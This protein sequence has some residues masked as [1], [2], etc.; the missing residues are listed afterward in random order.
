MTE[1]I[2]PFVEGS[3]GN[4]SRLATGVTVGSSAERIRHSQIWSSCSSQAARH[5]LWMI[6]QQSLQPIRR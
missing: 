6:T 1:V 2:D 3:A 5:Q 4:T